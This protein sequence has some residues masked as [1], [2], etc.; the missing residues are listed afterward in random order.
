MKQNYFI[1]H[2]KKKVKCKSHGKSEETCEFGSS[3]SESLCFKGGTLIM[4][5]PYSKF[6]F[7]PFMTSLFGMACFSTIWTSSGCLVIVH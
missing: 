2:E 6:L 3:K 5:G 1:W 4:L 7:L